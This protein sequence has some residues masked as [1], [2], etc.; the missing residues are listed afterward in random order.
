MKSFFTPMILKMAVLWLA[1][2]FVVHTA[3]AQEPP[4][5]KVKYAGRDFWMALYTPHYNIPQTGIANELYITGRANAAIRLT[6]T[7]SGA[8][9]N[10]TLQAGTI[11]KI[12]LTA[13]ELALIS[14]NQVEITGN[15][16]LHI[17]ADTDVVVQFAAWGFD[18][19]DGMIIF[20]SDRQQFGDVYYLNGP[21]SGITGIGTSTI[22]A[23]TVVA[24]CDNVVLEITPTRKTAL[25]PAGTPFTVNL[26]K[27]ESYTLANRWTNEIKDLSG[28][29]IEVIQASCCNAV[30]IF[31]THP[32]DYL[33][34]PYVLPFPCCAD[35]QLEQLLPV[36]VWDT[37]HHIVPYVNTGYTIIK[38]VSGAGNNV[39]SINGNVFATLNEGGILDTIIEMPVIIRSSGPA[40]ITQYMPSQSANLAYTMGADSFSDPNASW[41]IPIRDGIKESIF[42]TAGQRK[43]WPDG[44]SEV[45]NT[46]HVLC[47]VSKAENVNTITLNN[48]NVADEFSPFPSDAGYMYA[49]IRVDTGVVY[50]LLSAERIMACY[51]AAQGEGTID[52]HLGDI[53]PSYF[54]TPTTSDTLPV[55]VNDTTRLTTSPA[56]TYVWSTGETTEEIAVTDTGT[57]SVLKYYDDDCIGELERYTVIRKPAT[58]NPFNLGLDTSVCLGTRIVLSADD[59]RTVWSDNSTGTELVITEPGAYWAYVADPCADIV[60][61]DTIRVAY[62]EC[63][64]LFCRMMFPNAFSPNADGKNDVFKPAYYGAFSNY[65]LNIFNRWGQRVYSGANI[66]HGWD[67]YYKNVPAALDVYFYQCTYYCP[68]KGLTTVKGEVTLIR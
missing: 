62:V 65:I 32:S 10:Y 40:G 58:I 38:I 20:P 8:V 54:F 5:E 49:N 52:F 44:S 6:Y 57:Y 16:S 30:N 41:V 19:D 26:N 61:S 29:K 14:T 64:E 37:L 12:S 66:D 60:Y 27:G 59:P 23:F 50:H 11:L 18:N 42:Q 47:L 48:V 13:A 46:M 7:S 34:W 17:E 67:G 35:Q 4:P 22:G 21:S 39:F 33:A 31:N 36:A 55:C 2:M 63:P 1:G 68:V 56:L 24:T 15:K 43:Y 3:G 51:Y 53:N 9:Q 25:H 28:T 45:Y